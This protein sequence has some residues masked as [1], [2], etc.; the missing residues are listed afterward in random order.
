MTRALA[1]AV[2]WLALPL[3]KLALLLSGDRRRSL[4]ADGRASY[5]LAD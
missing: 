2:Y 5:W 1:F 4:R 3:Y